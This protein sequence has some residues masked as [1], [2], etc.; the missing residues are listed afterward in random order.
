MN[1]NKIFTILFIIFLIASLVPISDN[2]SGMDVKESQ[3]TSKETKGTSPYPFQNHYPSLS[4][5]YNWYDT[6][7]ENHP[8]ICNKTKIGESWEGRDLYV[9]KISDNVNTDE[10][11]P[12]ILID[13]GLHA[14][15]WSGPQ[16]ASYF[17]WRILNEYDT[18]DTIHWLVNNRE[19]FVAPML[20]PDGYY[21]DGNGDYSQ[22]SYWRKNR[23]DSTP[24][25]SVGVDLNRNWDIAW[26]QGD[27]D[28]GSNTYHGEAPHS[29]YEIR[30]YTDWILS[31]DIQS[32]QNLH[33]YAGTLLIP[34]CH[35]DDN[36]PHDS[37]YRSMAD[38]MTSLT[39][40]MGSNNHYSYGQAGEE[41]GYNAPGGANDWVYNATGA[42]GMCFEIETGGSDFYPPESDIMTINKDLDE[43]LIYQTRVTD[44][45]LGNGS[46]E[47]YPPAPYILYG[48]VYDV[49]GNPVTYN[50]LT[51][52]NN[53]TGETLNLNTDNN[54]Y[55]EFNFGNFVNDDYSDSDTFVLKNDDFYREI[56][57]GPEW[58]KK[59]DINYEDSEK[60]IIIDNSQNKAK[61]GMDY[62]LNITVEDQSNIEYV[63]TNYGFGNGIKV[64]CELDNIG[65]GEYQKIISIPSDCEGFYYNITVEDTSGNQNIT[66]TK[67]VPVE[68]VIKPVVNAG[69]DKNGSINEALTFN[70]ESCSDNLGIV[71]YTWTID[72]AKYYT[73]S[74]SHSFSMIG[75]YTASITVKDAD[76]NEA[77][78]GLNITITDS[79]KPTAEAGGD[80]TIKMNQETILDGANST[81][82]GNIKNYTWKIEGDEE[83]YK[84][85]SISYVFSEPGTYE[86]TLTVYD[87]S[88]N[89]DSDTIEIKVL[90]DV[91]PLPEFSLPEKVRISQN[92]E[93]DGTNSSD[94]HEINS[95]EWELGDENIKSGKT[96]S[97]SFDDLGCF[98]V[99][100]KV[101][102][103][104]GNNAELTKQIEVVDL[105][106]PSIKVSVPEKVNIHENITFDASKCSDNHQIRD[107][108]WK[109]NGE[110]L[111]GKSVNHSFSKIGEHTVELIIRDESGNDNSTIKTIEVIDEEAPKIRLD[112]PDMITLDESVTF[113][114]SN[115]SD[116][117]EIDLV[118]WD[119][120]GEEK[121]GKVINHSFSE[122]GYFE[123]I[124]TVSDTSN[125]TAQKMVNVT[126]EDLTDPMPDIS[127]NESGKVG[128]ELE[129]DASGST[130]NHNIK[131]YEWTF[132]DESV[133]KGKIV[134]HSFSEEGNHTVELK[135]TDDSGNTET[136]TDTVSID[137]EDSMESDSSEEDIP[138]F[139]FC[140]LIFSLGLLSILYTRER[141]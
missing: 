136:I 132:N 30:N 61:T 87:T 16:V 69:N 11:E 15:E 65:E 75:D 129:F 20:N 126:V 21:Y 140:L 107:F 100:L 50:N 82:N 104:S 23:N 85:R 13:G 92:L 58:G 24:T 35:K 97:H 88:G 86:V 46:S 99:T 41:I 111:S 98:N 2:T 138:G 4:E 60:P 12:E 57:I 64:G 44:I 66:D 59:V 95:F 125:N 29:E 90:D 56:N 113:D 14:R 133:K 42:H 112:Y 47:K 45:D 141:F 96:I 62:Y 79:T 81:D 68:D 72:D 73:E 105:T 114:G 83:K 32:Y 93:L 28:A 70:I 124:L 71:N 89:V 39:T 131:S 33:S 54:G 76:G 18:N 135:V 108:L 52:K 116:N 6:L 10:S 118:K 122:I 17:M 106:E 115:C 5:L 25:S 94:N 3:S 67:D 74:P 9:M 53:N 123:I 101:T 48:Q 19:I 91:N 7:E 134:K 40:K 109:I 22:R 1:R 63:R 121:I 27:D 34:W 36:S 43:S 102:D 51:L 120:K 38:D 130:D 78:D 128:E 55:F 49:Q 117:V 26:S 84:S 110:E 103:Y 8:N 139:T 137:S 80:R 119:M 37:W 127:C 77:T 31:R